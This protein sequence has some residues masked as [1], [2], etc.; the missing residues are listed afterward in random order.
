MKLFV[1]VVLLVSAVTIDALNKQK[2]CKCRSAVGQRL[3]GGSVASRLAH[4]WYA[5]IT[6][7]FSGLKVH[8]VTCGAVI[9]N[10]K[11]VLT[12]G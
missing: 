4:P 6:V 8:P 9:V 10:E 2:D 5:N 1:L 3:I 12:A 7:Q 11:T